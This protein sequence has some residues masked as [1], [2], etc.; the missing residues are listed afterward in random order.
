[1]TQPPANSFVLPSKEHFTCA[2]CQQMVIDDLHSVRWYDVDFCSLKCFRVYFECMFGVCAT[3]QN[4]FTD[5]QMQIYHAAH[6]IFAFCGA[7]CMDTYRQLNDPCSF[8]YVQCSKNGRSARTVG[9]KKY[10][11]LQCIKADGRIIGKIFSGGQC[12]MC[13][14]KHG[15]AY[16]VRTEQENLWNV[17]SN[18][19]L[20]LFE[21]DA[22]VKLGTC[23]VCHI[24]YDIASYDAAKMVEFTGEQRNFC[25]KVCLSYLLKNDTKERACIECGGSFRYYE[26]IRTLATAEAERTW[27]SLECADRHAS[28]LAPPR[29]SNT[30]IELVN[31]ELKGICGRALPE[32]IR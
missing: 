19:C 2:Q 28:A 30:H 14:K 12:Y 27:C 9:K 22:K 29:L 24:K 5:G 7:D 13:S 11:S 3:C 23:S 4:A 6:S 20:M 31:R 17:C 21:L 15:I 25:S 32:F 26:M 1:M 8:C 16:Q 10:C 18:D